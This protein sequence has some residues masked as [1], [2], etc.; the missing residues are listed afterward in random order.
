MWLELLKVRREKVRDKNN[1]WR[2]SGWKISKF[3]ENYKSMDPS[4][5]TIQNAYKTRNIKKTKLRPI[6]IKLLHPAIKRRILKA[7]K[8]IYHIQRNTDKDNSRF[9]IRNNASVRNSVLS[10]K[11]LS[12]YNLTSKIIF[13]KQRILFCI[14][15]LEM[16]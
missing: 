16:F 12:T 4:R 9:C 11:K 13:Q 2:V 14:C 8:E 7:V 10:G 5:S 6:I 15:M 1:I 3:D